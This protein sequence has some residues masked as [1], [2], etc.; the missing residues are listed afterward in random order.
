[1]FWTLEVTQ[2]CFHLFFNISFSHMRK[3]MFF[4]FWFHSMPYEL[5]WW[6][7]A[8]FY[9]II[10]SLGLEF[11]YYCIQSISCL[12]LW[13]YNIFMEPHCYCFNYF[14]QSNSPLNYLGLMSSLVVWITKSSPLW[15]TCV[16]TCYLSGEDNSCIVSF[17]FVGENSRVILLLWDLQTSK[18]SW[19]CTH[20]INHL[21]EIGVE[22]DEYAKKRTHLA[23][24]KCPD[25]SA[26]SFCKTLCKQ[27]C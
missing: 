22:N 1:M 11:I 24:S 5:N 13:L 8:K 10:W 4:C 25:K 27:Q 9:Q 17:L 18:I 6:T 2:S 26:N 16:L 3:S 19:I 14:D 21:M 15:V 20:A 12:T 7:G 23:Y